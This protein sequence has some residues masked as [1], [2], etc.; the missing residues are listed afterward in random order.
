MGLSRVA[1]QD[2]GRTCE[3]SVSEFLAMPLDRRVRLVLEQQIEFYD[4]A[5]RRLSTADGLKLL[6]GA[7]DAEQVATR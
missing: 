3:M 4:E 1:V 6:R 2:G 7:R 5:G